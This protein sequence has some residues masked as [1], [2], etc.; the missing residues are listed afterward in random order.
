MLASYVLLIARSSY[1]W[2]LIPQ[3][4]LTYR[5]QYGKALS[6]LFLFG[7]LNG[8]LAFLLYIFCRDLPLSYKIIAPLETVATMVIIGQ[9]IYYDQQA[10]WKLAL[11]YIINAGFYLS[12]V[13][14]G[15]Y[16]PIKCGNTFGWLAFLI[17]AV[18]QLPQVIKIFKEKSVHGF[19]FLFVLIFGFASV[20]ELSGS[21]ALQLP[22]QTIISSLRGILFFLIFCLQFVIYK[23]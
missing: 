17:S 16:D 22:V 7:Y 10:S 18:N 6:D 14:W 15:I 21:L 9:R 23:R 20:A 3:I 19:S 1:L 11:L 2:C 4:I 12:A 5:T 13:P 8:Y